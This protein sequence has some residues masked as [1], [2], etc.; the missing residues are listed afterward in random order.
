M[1][2][3]ARAPDARARSTS[4][5]AMAAR[6]DAGGPLVVFA[7]GQPYRW[8][9]GGVNIPFNPDQGGLGP[10]NNAQAVAQTAAAFAAWAAIPSA[11]ATHVNA[12]ALSVDVDVTNFVPFLQPTEPDGLSAIVFDEDG[13]IFDVA[14]RR[15]TPAFSA[16]PDRNG[17]TRPPASSSKACAFMNGGALVGPDAFPIGEFLS[18]QVH[19]F[20]HYQNLAHTVSTARSRASATTRARRRTTRSRVPATFANRIETMYPFLFVN[21]GQATPHEDDIAMFSTLY[22]EPGFAASHRHD[23]RPDPRAEQHDADHRRQRDRAQR[24]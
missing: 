6:T 5:L 9:N 24:G 1:T 2:R 20:G 15:P 8:A 19:E 23:H 13:E 10:L 18:V 17:S 3:H 16:S 7:P 4:F 12:G 22:P 11:T 14:V 21:G